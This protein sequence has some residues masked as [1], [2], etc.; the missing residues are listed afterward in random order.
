MIIKIIMATRILIV[1]LL[2]RGFV[3]LI[4]NLSFFTFKMMTITYL[5]LASELS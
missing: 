3:T 1:A 2:L 5:A 4:F